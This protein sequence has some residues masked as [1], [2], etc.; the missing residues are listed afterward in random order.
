MD[1]ARLLLELWGPQIYILLPEVV[2]KVKEEVETVS[3]RKKRSIHFNSNYI[4]TKR[5]YSTIQFFLPIKNLPVNLA[6]LDRLPASSI[7][8][9]FVVLCRLFSL[10]AKSY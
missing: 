5:Q 4:R 2:N 10:S 9:K 1:I 3:S 6:P 7:F 8:T